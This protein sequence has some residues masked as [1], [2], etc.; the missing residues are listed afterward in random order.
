MI[1]PVGD[2]TTMWVLPDGDFVHGSVLAV[3]TTCWSLE[4]FRQFDRCPPAERRALA[5]MIDAIHKAEQMSVV[6]IT[7]RK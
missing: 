3:D 7:I 5:Q 6:E 1:E 2:D 4:D